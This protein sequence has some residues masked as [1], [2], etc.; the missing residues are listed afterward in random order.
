MVRTQ[1]SGDGLHHEGVLRR[2]KGPAPLAPTPLVR[3]WARGL[4]RPAAAMRSLPDTGGARIGLTAV[5]TRFALQD[6]TETLPLVLLGRRPFTPS[7]LPTGPENHYRVQ[8]AFLPVFGLGEW[9]L[10]S[11]TAQVVLRLTGHHSDLRRVLDVIGLGM[12]I[13]MPPLWLGEAALIAADRFR[14]PELGFVTV[15]TQVWE[16]ALFGVGL[17]AA[18]DVPW[19]PA[20]LAGAAASTVY[21]LG[22]S[23]LVR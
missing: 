11:G 23:Q 10:M 6:L 17:H 14:L 4:T 7:R 22:A 8:L 9:L 12:L 2:P 19:R 1:D 16:T 13:P 18:L 5:L 21:V 15:P 3:R 20:V